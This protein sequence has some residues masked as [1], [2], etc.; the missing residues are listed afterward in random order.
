MKDLLDGEDGKEPM[1]F[2]N[3]ILGLHQI[4]LLNLITILSMAIPLSSLFLEEIDDSFAIIGALLILLANRMYHLAENQNGSHK[5]N[6]S[7]P[8][9]MDGRNKLLNSIGTSYRNSLME[10]LVS[11]GFTS[12]QVEVAITNR[13]REVSKSLAYALNAGVKSTAMRIMESN[14]SPNGSYFAS[15]YNGKKYFFIFGSTNEMLTQFIRDE[16]Q[17]IL[18]DSLPFIFEL[19]KIKKD[20]TL[21]AS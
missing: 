5:H 8:D 12:E 1:V 7:S 2:R 4:D 9:D 20:D 18:E 3:G 21:V 14:L 11:E 19:L 16:L 15:P 10:R 17:N 13:S 6:L